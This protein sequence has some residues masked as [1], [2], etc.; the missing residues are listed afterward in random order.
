KLCGDRKK[1]QRAL[2]RHETVVHLPKIKPSQKL[3]PQK[4]LETDNFRC[5][6]PE[7]GKEFADL[8]NLKQ[9]QTRLRHA[10]ERFLQKR[11]QCP[12]EGCDYQANAW[13]IL[14][15]HE[16]K[17]TGDRPFSCTENNCKFRARS[18]DS[19]NSH[20]KTFHTTEKKF[21][22]DHPG[23]NIMFKAKGNF[24]KHINEVHTDARPYPCS[25]PE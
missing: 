6:W 18:Q 14:E 4:D 21:R 9:H 16:R 7:C 15:I 19:V 11:L 10:D 20:L 1:N 2:R 22:C 25:W 13:N 5:D 12:W 17:H 24:L 8:A 3:E 23:C